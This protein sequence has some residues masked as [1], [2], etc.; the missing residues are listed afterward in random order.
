MVPPGPGFSKLTKAL[1]VKDVANWPDNFGR[2]LRSF[3]RG[4]GIQPIRTLS[5]FS[6]AGGL[7]IAFHDAGFDI[8]QMVEIHPKYAATLELNAKED[9]YFGHG[10]VSAVD[11]RTLLR[12]VPLAFKG[13]IDCIIGGP[14]C[15]TFSAAGRRA[16]GVRGTQE[17]R[18]TL[19]E[20]YVNLLLPREASM[21][22]EV[23][24]KRVLSR[25]SVCLE[26]DV[27]DPR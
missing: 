1:G 19:F 23:R 10:T 16:A 4:A 21:L 3:V 18:G 7:D 26:V 22:E 20:E 5:L 13:R 27:L 17:A 12:E 25:Q 8:L 2:R 15:Q 9:G 24:L 14:P 11:V 6:G